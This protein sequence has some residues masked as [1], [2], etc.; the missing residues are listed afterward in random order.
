R[1]RA[2]RPSSRAGH[3]RRRPRGAVTRR[4]RDWV[5]GRQ[6]LRPLALL[7]DAESGRTGLA[8][9]RAALTRSVVGSS[10]VI[11]GSSR[12]GSRGTAVDVVGYQS[13]P[14]EG[15]IVPWKGAEACVVPCPRSCSSS[16]PSGPPPV[17]LPR[18]LPAEGRTVSG[19]P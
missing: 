4:P 16:S 12:A 14:L 10:P 8:L 15:R 9:A 3:G 1:I 7:R 11:R 2:P 13:G 19:P 17:A 5:L 6:V 18:Q